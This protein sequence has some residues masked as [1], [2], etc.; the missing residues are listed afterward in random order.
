[1]TSPLLRLQQLGQSPWHDNIRRAQLTSGALERMVAEG[2]ITGLTSNPTIFEQAIANS[3]DY[4]ADIEALARQGKS[5]E[6]IFDALA[7]ADIQAAADVF[8]PVYER[9]GGADGYVSIEV[10]PR[11]AHDTDG[12]IREARRLWKAVR[13]P[14]LMVKIPA[15]REGLPAIQRC[16]AEGININ[17]TLIFA[18]DR[19]EAVIDAY[20]AALEERRAA[21]KK[22]DRIASVASFFVSRVDTLV[23]RQLDE[24][25]QAI[26]PSRAAAL[27]ALR[28]QAAIANAG[29][30]YALFRRK[31]SQQRFAPLAERGARLQRPLWASTSTKNPAYPDVYYVE[32][33][34]G[35]DTVNTMPPATL[36]AY[37][38]HGQPDVRIEAGHQQALQVIE[39]LE[40]A[41]I[42]MDDVTARLEAEGVRSFA[43]SFDSL[44]DVVDARREAVLHGDRQ[45]L[46]LPGRPAQKLV[47]GALAELSESDFGRRLWAK[48]ASLWKPD[49]PV[50]QAEIRN[51]LGWLDVLDLMQARASEMTTF[52]GEVRR[53]GFTHGLLC[54]MG[55]S[56]LAP[57]VLRQ[58]FGVAP[59]WLDLAV[60][61]STDPAAVASAEA[62]SSPARTLYIIA[63]KSGTTTEPNAFFSYFWKR[64]QA[65]KGGRSGENFVA[66][67]DPGTAMEVVAQQNNFRRAFLNPPDIGGRY[68]ALSYFGLVP[69]ALMGIDIARLLARAQAMRRACAAVIPPAANPGL[70]LGAILGAL[71]RA[72]RDKLTLLAGPGLESF[73]YWIEQLVAESTGKEGLGILPVE[74]EK[75]GPP[76]VYHRQHD[77]LFVHMRLDGPR[78][79]QDRAVDALAEA[80]HPVV[81]LRLAG[82]YD[83]GGEFL[84][85]E[86][87]TAAAG[88]FLG[89]N[90]FDQP[91]VQE[92]KDNTVR[93]LAAHASHGT[94]PDAGPRLQPIGRDFSTRLRRHLKSARRGDYVA[95]LAYFERTPQRERLLRRL[96]AAIRDQFSLAVTVGYGPRFLHSTGQLHKGGPNNGVF[97][98]LT[99]S[100][101]VDAAVPGET[102]TFG[103]LKSAQALGD[104][105]ALEAR[106]RRVLRIA[107]GSNIHAGLRQALEAVSSQASAAPPAQRQSRKTAGRRPNGAGKAASDNGNSRKR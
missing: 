92:S 38:D 77:R 57:E 80:G 79:A 47:E 50:H 2:D 33:L 31:F 9:T 62:R 101:M 29:L 93:L 55:G 12:T 73:G 23:D 104:Y 20:L 71:A 98:Q 81:S 56:S 54:G 82:A 94:L 18:L 25:I 46:R 36:V 99:A 60:L 84:R 16:L 43:A 95:L 59:G 10:A 35:P 76:E 105:Q 91:D 37:K 100:D 7:I 102:Y 96:Q 65:V 6:E 40:E 86:I 103:V 26:G 90:P 63:S 41:G 14:N 32:A 83:L 58:T 52:A 19:Y 27:E 24:R 67:T 4:D 106:G 17:I 89:I 78:T 8:A 11:F 42:R 69:A 13:R 39:Q 15:T 72:G 45:Q 97:V 21:N 1:M 70:S 87:A 44:I 75:L 74:G 49:D 34:I 53:A 61:D 48:D 28:G 85:W 68:S 22:I 30:A 66:I 64:V 107:L 51:R 5:A 88:W 3:D